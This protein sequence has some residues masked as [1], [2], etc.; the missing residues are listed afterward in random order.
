[1][2]R[3]PEA[4]RGLKARPASVESSGNPKK[5]KRASPRQKRKRKGASLDSAEDSEI[6]RTIKCTM[7]TGDAILASLQELNQRSLVMQMQAQCKEATTTDTSKPQKGHRRPPTHGA[8][9]HKWQKLSTLRTNDKNS[10]ART[11]RTPK[12]ALT[13]GRDHASDY[14]SSTTLP[15]D[16]MDKETQGLKDS[17]SN[18]A[19]LIDNIQTTER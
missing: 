3:R 7:G 15:M 6:L 9:S 14:D 2:G 10:R 5:R 19:I 13:D 4:A 1:M 18:T 17:I 8:P 11:L 16:I 12:N